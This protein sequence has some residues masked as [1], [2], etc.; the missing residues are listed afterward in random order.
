MLACDF[1]HKVVLVEHFVETSYG[2]DW[3]SETL[4]LRGSHADATSQARHHKH[5]ISGTFMLGL[6]SSAAG[7]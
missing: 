5:G 1:V 4:K 7:R 3:P 2:I 6:I